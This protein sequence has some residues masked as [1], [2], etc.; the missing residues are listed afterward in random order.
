[1]QSERPLP[2]TT[3]NAPPCRTDRVGGQVGL[4]LATNDARDGEFV[5]DVLI[6]ANADAGADAAAGGAGGGGAVEMHAQAAV[7]D[8][9]VVVARIDGKQ[10][11]AAAVST[12]CHIVMVVIIVL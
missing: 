3:T 6:G 12:R 2:T 4:R 7:R 5:V 9:G 8:D 10:Y 11:E 1:M